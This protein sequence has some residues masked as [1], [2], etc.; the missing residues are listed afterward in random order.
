MGDRCPEIKDR[1]LKKVLIAGQ[2]PFWIILKLASPQIPNSSFMYPDRRVYR[3]TTKD[4]VEDV[5]AGTICYQEARDG[6]GY[7]DPKKRSI[8]CRAK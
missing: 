2:R 3:M 5:P 1:S 7:G 8:R 4:L 6:R